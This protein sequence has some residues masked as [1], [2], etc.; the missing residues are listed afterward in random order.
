[1]RTRDPALVAQDRFLEGSGVEIHVADWGGDGPIAL[2]HHGTGLHARTWDP[3]ARRLSARFHVIAMDARGHGKS[4]KPASDYAWERLIADVVAL[5][6]RLGSAV[7]LGIGHSLG[8]TILA[9]AS[10]RAPGA[11][12]RIE[13]LVLVDPI[14]YPRSLRSLPPEE[15]PMVPP[16]LKRKAVWPS[17]EAMIESY[18]TRRPFDTWREESLRDYVEH[19][20]E[21]RPDGQVELSCPPRVEAQ[22]FMRAAEFL[23][24]EMLPTV[25]VPTLM[26][27]GE[28]SDAFPAPG[29]AEALGLLRR[30]RLVT[31]PGTTHFLPMEVPDAVAD[32]A[33]AFMDEQEPE[34]V[35]P[36]PHR[37]LAHLALNA[38]DLE[39][40]LAFYRDI[41]GMKVVWQPDPDNV[42]LS[43]G[44]DNL[45][46]HR[47]TS[48]A[49]PGPGALDHLGFFVERPAYVYAAAEA[50]ERR[51][52]PLAKPPQHHR[53]GSCSLY[54]A[55]PDGNMIQ[56]LYVPGVTGI[57]AGFE[58]E[59]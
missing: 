17:R 2:L 26:L 28:K 49:V 57:S 13:R 54:V 21:I 18:R 47:S 37:G 33:L 46:L 48:A 19:G 36:I 12:G 30:G 6:G 20:T 56:I 8:G 39:A 51:G 24:W 59:P 41:L 11:L 44:P 5:I 22:L 53:D 32:L 45:A 3:V 4:E 38:R 52:I 1:M 58:N 10:V 31:I 34:P 35:L 16:T 14:F 27:R 40:M 43:S 23:G 25:T 15:R 55:D 50:L 29:A 42:Y 7:A 9:G